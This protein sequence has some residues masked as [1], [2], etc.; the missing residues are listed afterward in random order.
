VRASLKVIAARI[1]PAADG[2][3]KVPEKAPESLNFLGGRR[4]DGRAGRDMFSEFVQRHVK[5]FGGRPIQSQHDVV[6]HPGDL[7]TSGSI[8]VC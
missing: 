1:A 6:F 2:V 4:S 8:V 3:S 5:V 7:T